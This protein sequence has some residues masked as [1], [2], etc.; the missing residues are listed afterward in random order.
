MYA[1]PPPLFHPGGVVTPPSSSFSAAAA[2]LGEGR[3]HE[4]NTSF[5]PLQSIAAAC[6][7]PGTAR[8]G[9]VGRQCRS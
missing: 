6:T 1:P 4:M 2:G 3:E 9:R 5:A 8:H 7:L